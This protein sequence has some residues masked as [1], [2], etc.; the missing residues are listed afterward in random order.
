MQSSLIYLEQLSLF[1]DSRFVIRKIFESLDMIGKEKNLTPIRSQ[2]LQNVAQRILAWSTRS[3]RWTT[4]PSS[5][6]II[7]E[8]LFLGGFLILDINVWLGFKYLIF[9][10]LKNFGLSIYNF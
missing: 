2:V 9:L 10:V 6:E 1:F 3:N 4:T 7:L 5:M 8:R